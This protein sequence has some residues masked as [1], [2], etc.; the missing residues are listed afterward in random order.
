MMTVPAILVLVESRG[1]LLCYYNN[2]L[3]VLAGDVKMASSM[4]TNFS[5]FCTHMYCMHT[6]KRH[7]KYIIIRT[8]QR[9]SYTLKHLELE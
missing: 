2:T 7:I 3:F 1:G 6:C 8:S 5:A 9:H 4:T